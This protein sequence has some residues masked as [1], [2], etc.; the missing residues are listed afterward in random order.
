MTWRQ[1][2]R[3]IVLV[4]IAAILASP[5][6]APTARLTAA[7][8]PAAA[9]QSGGSMRVVF[10]GDIAPATNE[11]RGDDHA[12]AEVTNKLNPDLICLNGDVQYVY[13]AREMFFSPVGFDGSWGRLHKPRIK[14]PAV[15]NHDVADPGPGAPGFR[16]YF[17]D[18]LSNLP[19]RSEPNPCR[20][21]LGYYIIDLPVSP[22]ASQLGWYVVVIDSDCGRAGG[23]TGDTETPLCGNSDPMVQWMRD[24]I[25]RRAGTRK[26]GLVVDHHERWG[27]SFF[28]DD[29]ALNYP[30]QVGN[31]FRIELWESGHTHSTGRLGPMSWDGHLVNSGAGQ[32]QLTSGAGGASLTPVRVNPPREGTRYRDNTKFGVNQLTLTSTPL[33]DGTM[34]G[35]W[36]TAFHYADGSVADQ[37]SAACWL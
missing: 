16:A 5:A 25:G 14:C 19:C 15:G 23:G 17:T 6:V 2:V 22:G 24:A 7:A 37:A 33:P 1:G 13:G 18:A 32:R 10:V 29:P 35:S 27:T 9:L 31:H 26:C 34:G 20:P 8:A 36:S 12:T 21:D 3:S 28:A 11:T 4:V 30:W